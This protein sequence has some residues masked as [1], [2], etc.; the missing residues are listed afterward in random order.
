MPRF[1][2]MFNVIAMT[3]SHTFMVMFSNYHT[4][5]DARGHRQTTNKTKQV[6]TLG[7]CHIG[8]RLSISADILHVE[9]DQLVPLS[10]CINTSVCRD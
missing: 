7:G 9:Q 2:P 5:I 4:C 6:C 10:D 8:T 3:S 1:T